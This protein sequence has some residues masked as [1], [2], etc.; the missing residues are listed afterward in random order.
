VTLGPATVGFDAAVHD[1]AMTGVVDSVRLSSTARYTAAFTPPTAKLGSD[2]F[3]LILLNFDANPPGLTQA[4][5][6]AGHPV[7]LPV[8]RLAEPD[9]SPEGTITGTTIRSLALAGEGIVGIN[10]VAGRYT[11]LVAEYTEYGIALFGTS[12]GSVFDAIY[13]LAN[14]Q[15]GRYGLVAINGDDSVY[16]WILSDYPQLPLV[17][18]GGANQRFDDLFITPQTTSTLYGS[19]FIQSGDTVEGLYFDNEAS[20][21]VW[22]GNMVVVQP[23]ARF[24]LFKGEI[25]NMTNQGTPI[26]IDGGKGI[27]VEGTSFGHSGVA[28][29]LIHLNSATT[30]ANVAI[31][32]TLDSTTKLSDDPAL[33]SIGN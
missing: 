28:P 16:H 19:Y 30:Q 22:K 4:I 3:S 20:S 7:W 32:V 21:T 9:G 26:T 25:D 2:A 11:D 31:G 29:E 12:A 24:Q 6:V 13:I 27:L 15:R 1:P 8:R 10:A 5:D 14:N 23:T 33:E 17:V 18:Y